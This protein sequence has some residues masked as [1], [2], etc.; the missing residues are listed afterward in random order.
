[1][2]ARPDETVGTTVAALD[3]VRAAFGLRLVCGPAAMRIGAVL[4]LTGCLLACTPAHDPRPDLDAGSADSAGF[5][6]AEETHLDGV[7][8]E[9][10]RDVVVAGFRWPDDC[11]DIVLCPIR[12]CTGCLRWRDDSWDAGRYSTQLAEPRRCR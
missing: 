12:G 5:A 9:T 8:Q 1:M 4:A 11:R 3:R 10:L 6:V 7:C 2:P